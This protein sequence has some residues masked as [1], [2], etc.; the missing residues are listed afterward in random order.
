MAS[1]QSKKDNEIKIKSGQETPQKRPDGESWR[2]RIDR[3][4]SLKER[5]HDPNN[6]QVSEYQVPKHKSEVEKRMAGIVKIINCTDQ[7]LTIVV[8]EGDELMLTSGIINQ[9][10]PDGPS[11]DQTVILEN[12]QHR[13]Q[14]KA[15]EIEKLEGITSGPGWL[16][17]ERSA[18]TKNNFFGESNKLTIKVPGQKDFNVDE[19]AIPPLSTALNKNLDMLVFYTGAVLSYDGRVIWHQVMTAQEFAEGS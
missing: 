16:Y 9:I 8:N 10:F 5:N 14:S 19:L 7:D 11:A 13:N 1:E 17:V 4:E 18:D 12:L 3:N 15:Q 2:V 6:Q